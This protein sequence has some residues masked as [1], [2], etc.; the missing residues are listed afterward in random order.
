[1]DLS[2]RAVDLDSHVE[3]H[4]LFSA[5]DDHRISIVTSK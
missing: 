1:M 4:V 5:F 3:V 2:N